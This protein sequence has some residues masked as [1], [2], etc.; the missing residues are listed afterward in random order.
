MDNTDGPKSF[1]TKCV[2]IPFP[3]VV[4]SGNPRNHYKLIQNTPAT[5][6]LCNFITCY[7]L[8]QHSHYKVSSVCDVLQEIHHTR[9]APPLQYP[10][11]MHVIPCVY[12]VYCEH[13]PLPTGIDL[14]KSDQYVISGELS[15]QPQSVSNWVTD[16]LCY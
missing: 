9:T 11:A 8:K 2:T 5:H 15:H 14:L 13:I 10:H 1:K 6:I 12:N 16:K 3:P 4:V 7:L